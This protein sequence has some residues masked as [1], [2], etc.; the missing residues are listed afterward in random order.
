MTYYEQDLHS[1]RQTE[2]HAVNAQ[3]QAMRLRE[4]VRKLRE[5]KRQAI[6]HHIMNYDEF[7]KS[8]RRAHGYNPDSKEE[9]VKH[10]YDDYREQADKKADE[11]RLALE[12]A[13][14]KAGEEARKLK[15]ML[16][17]LRSM[18]RRIDNHLDELTRT[19]SH[20]NQ[21]LTLTGS[22]LTL[23]AIATMQ[24]ELQSTTWF[25]DRVA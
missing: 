25:K 13:R 8:I 10:K 5:A 14:T 12:Q 23:D 16:D 3:G 2:V 24:R 18:L 7:L 21:A 1:L 4:A 19:A 9:T 22:Q 17:E 15:L 20:A 6:E 11:L